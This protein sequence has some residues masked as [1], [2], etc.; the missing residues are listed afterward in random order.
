MCDE[1]LMYQA[2]SQISGDGFLS[3]LL[4]MGCRLT[5]SVDLYLV[6]HKWEGGC[7]HAVHSYGSAAKLFSVT[8]AFSLSTLHTLLLICTLPKEIYLKENAV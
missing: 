3:V 4:A 6:A 5:Y 2:R 1:L 7:L 8:T